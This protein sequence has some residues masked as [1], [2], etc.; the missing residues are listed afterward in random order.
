MVA[1]KQPNKAGS[2]AAEAVVRMARAEGTAGPPDARRAQ[3]R[4]SV[5]QG[6]DRIR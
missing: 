6:L 5:S 4:K 2:P 3:N 1:R